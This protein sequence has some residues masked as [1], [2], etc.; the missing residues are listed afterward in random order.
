MTSHRATRDGA[1]QT[2]DFAGARRGTFAAL[3]RAMRLLVLG[4]LAICCT[5][6]LPDRARSTIEVATG[7]G[8]TSARV[9][10]TVR[11]ADGRRLVGARVGVRVAARVCWCLSD[12]DGTGVVVLEGLPP[13]RAE[14]VATVGGI[15]LPPAP[16][17]AGAPL[18]PRVAP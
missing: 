5:S 4:L 13:G 1:A 11:D 7:F 17:V 14:A 10:V 9:A 18:V 16:F 12:E 8:G 15:E 2:R 6:P 3:S